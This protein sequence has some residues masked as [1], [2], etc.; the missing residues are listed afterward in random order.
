LLISFCET[1]RIGQAARQL[2]SLFSRY[3]SLSY[4]NLFISTS[5]L[6]VLIQLCFRVDLFIWHDIFF[7][8]ESVNLFN[9]A[10]PYCRTISNLPREPFPPILLSNRSPT[11][12]LSSF[13]INF[14]KP[15]LRY[16]GEISN[17]IDR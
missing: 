7:G 17:S 13:A 5:S 4:L 6:F 3:L 2:K 15:K 10:M 11:K 14:H 12:V 9:P 1:K 8:H 16:R